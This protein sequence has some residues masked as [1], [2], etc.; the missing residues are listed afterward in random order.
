MTRTVQG[1]SGEDMRNLLTRCGR[2]RILL[3]DPTNDLLI[4]AASTR[5]SARLTPDRLKARINTTLDELVSLRDR[6]GGRLEIRV[7][8]FPP[9][10]GMNVIDPYAPSGVLVVQHKQYK[11]LGESAPI[12]RFKRADGFW[13]SRFVDEAERLWRMAVLGR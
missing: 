13:F 8:S 12:M 5:D 9:A 3:L 1:S 11:P 4:R 7:A 10:M 6:T 2:I